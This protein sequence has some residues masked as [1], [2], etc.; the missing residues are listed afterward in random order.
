MI[1]VLQTNTNRNRHGAHDLLEQTLM[2]GSYDVAVVSEP[3]HFRTQGADWETD[4]G[5]DA[6]LWLSRNKRGEV[7]RKGRGRRYVW[8]D[9]GEAVVYSC[10][11]SPNSTLE[12]YEACLEE[13]EASVEMWGQGETGRHRGRLQ[14]S[15]RGMGQPE[16]EQK[17]RGTHGTN[18]QE[19]SEAGKRRT[20]TDLQEKRE[21]VIPRPH[22]VLWGNGESDWELACLGHRNTKRSHV[23][24]IRDKNGRAN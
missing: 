4:E 13:L 7:R 3:N 20:E 14:R 1:R 12:E 17:R 11:K 8:A 23:H 18:R 15:V 21:G 22:N 6:G 2:M 9:L 16:L 19:R 24:H 10:Y 5:K